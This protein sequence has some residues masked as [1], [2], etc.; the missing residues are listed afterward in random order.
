MKKKLIV[1]SGILLAVLLVGVCIKEIKKPQKIVADSN[2]EVIEGTNISFESFGIDNFMCTG[3]TWDSYD[4][5]F[6]IGDYGAL[7]N[8]ET[9][10]PR[11]V[12]VDKALKNVIQTIDLSSILSTADNLQG[13][14]F[15]N[16]NNSLWL[17]IGKTVKNI[18]KTGTVLSE[19]DLGKYSKYM[20]NGICVD[21]EDGTLWVLCYSRYLLHYDKFGNLIKKMN[22]NFRD[23]DHIVVN[24]DQIWVTAG[25]DY[26][27]DENYVLTMD[28]NSGDISVKYK[29]IGAYAVEGICI[30][31]SNMYIANDGLYHN[32]K[33]KESYISAYKVGKE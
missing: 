14:A 3:L 24:A 33:I 30:V 13:V 7:T 22:V 12:E 25:A 26:N 8:T 23:Q 18:D 11:L 19:F 21:S 5:A 17:A 16:S 2:T 1:F 32:A 9:P 15:D 28:K 31:G 29:V 10:A 4:S 6:W 27:G 20:A